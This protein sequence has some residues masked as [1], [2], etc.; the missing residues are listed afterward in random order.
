[1]GFRTLESELLL[2]VVVLIITI[3]MRIEVQQLA[4]VVD[5]RQ[6]APVRHGGSSD[7]KV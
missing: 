6:L 1:M 5:S 3:T 4:G 2:I 7:T